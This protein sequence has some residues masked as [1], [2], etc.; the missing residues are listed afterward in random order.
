MNV[1]EKFDKVYISFYF[2]SI[3]S[4]FESFIYT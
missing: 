4:S 1:N 3:I 2:Y